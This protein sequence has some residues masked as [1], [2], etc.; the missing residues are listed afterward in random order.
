MRRGGMLIVIN[1]L[2][3]HEALSQDSRSSPKLANAKRSQHLYVAG[4]L[5]V[6]Q[7]D[8]RLHRVE[9]LAE[10]SRMSHGDLNRAKEEV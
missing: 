1:E 9:N 10:L 4:L 2:A 6:F 3:G 7:D 5:P 8:D